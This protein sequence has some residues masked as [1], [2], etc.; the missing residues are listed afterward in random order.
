M[1]SI[2]AP[3]H[4]GSALIRSRRVVVTSTSAAYD[5]CGGRRRGKGGS[6][7]ATNLTQGFDRPA[8][9]FGASA[10]HEGGVSARTPRAESSLKSVFCRGSVVTNHGPRRRA[11]CTYVSIGPSRTLSY[12]VC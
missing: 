12:R 8:D 1:V 4:A 2:I 5:I 9:G 7:V 3:A 6:F 11:R 10:A